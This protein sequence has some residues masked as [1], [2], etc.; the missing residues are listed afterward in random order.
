MVR[1]EGAESIF[2]EVRES[3]L[4]ARSFYQD[5]AFVESGRR[6]GYYSDPQEDAV[7]YRFQLHNFAPH[8]VQKNK[9]NQSMKLLDL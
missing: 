6:K 1:A 3:N 7:V 9:G 8:S 2:L 4:A 5:S